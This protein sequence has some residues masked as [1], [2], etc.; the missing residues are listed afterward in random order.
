MSPR[1]SKASSVLAEG[2][3]LMVAGGVTAAGAP[4][5]PEPPLT[6]EASATN[7]FLE[8][9]KTSGDLLVEHY[10]DVT[11]SELPY[12]IRRMITEAGRL[13]TRLDGLDRLLAGDVDTWMEISEVRGGTLEV[14][15]DNVMGEARQGAG[16]LRQMITEIDRRI[17]ALDSAA[18]ADDDPTADL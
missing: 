6:V 3:G 10:A 4:I 16:V 2:V 7:P 9:H 1:K 12:D 11:E 18:G 5:A 14:R 15:V 17:K 13:S 8:A